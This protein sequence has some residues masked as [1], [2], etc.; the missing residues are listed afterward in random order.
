MALMQPF[1]SSTTLFYGYSSIDSTAGASG[2]DSAAAGHPSPRLSAPHRLTW[3]TDAPQEED[4]R[5]GPQPARTREEDDVPTRYPRWAAAGRLL[6]R[7]T[8]IG[9][10]NRLGSNA[11]TS[12]IPFS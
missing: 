9:P 6:G 7:V 1:C 2:S 5:K 12:A 10:Y 8:V 3:Q 11:A 4:E